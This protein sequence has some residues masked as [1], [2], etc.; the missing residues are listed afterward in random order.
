MNTIIEQ[1]EKYVIASLPSLEVSNQLTYER[2]IEVR[3][4]AK[5]KQKL[6][7]ETFNPIIEKAHAS[8]KQ[9]TQTRAKYLDPIVNI[10]KTIDSNVRSWKIE[11]E[12]K[13][14]EEQE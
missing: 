14:A 11:C 13:A 8:H 1:E 6:I 7:E 2:V 9:A 5:E 10:I 3:N 4:L 12:R